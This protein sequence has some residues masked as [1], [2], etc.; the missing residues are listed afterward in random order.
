MSTRSGSSRPFV[1][2]RGERHDITHKNFIIEG[3]PSVMKDRVV[4]LVA[5]KLCAEEAGFSYV[6]L[7][8]GMQTIWSLVDH[9]KTVEEGVKR[10]RAIKGPGWVV[11]DHLLFL[12]A[13][14]FSAIAKIP[15]LTEEAIAA[16]SEMRDS[17]RWVVV[18]E[19]ASV[20]K[21]PLWQDASRV[22]YGTESLRYGDIS[23]L[24]SYYSRAVAEAR[25]AGFHIDVLPPCTIAGGVTSSLVQTTYSILSGEK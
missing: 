19:H 3:P 7:F 18:S 11:Q 1:L 10:I 23:K 25:R 17:C 9:A 6:N 16:A 15:Q 4:A 20:N 22:A 24:T 21:K 2:I 13:R 14:A 5:R 8:G 12:L